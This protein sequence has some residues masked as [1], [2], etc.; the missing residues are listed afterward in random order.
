MTN[1]RP[2]QP[3]TPPP[4]FFENP[5]PL[6]VFHLNTCYS[7]SRPVLS[8]RWLRRII[9]P[10]ASTPLLPPGRNAKQGAAP[11]RKPPPQR[12]GPG[13][14]APNIASSDP[15]GEPWRAERRT[16]LSSGAGRYAAARPRPTARKAS[17][18]LQ[19]GEQARRPCAGRTRRLGHPP[20]RRRRRGR[21][22]R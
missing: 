9:R 15:P 6:T 16:V 12:S 19:L 5:P 8:F 20:S 2:V 3:S 21:D 7:Q 18:R 22:P 1:E 17:S 13:R 11:P 10:S 4:R 14:P